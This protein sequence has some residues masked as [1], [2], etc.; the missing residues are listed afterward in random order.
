MSPF[1]G[2]GPVWSQ[3]VDSLKHNKNNRGFC[4]LTPPRNIQRNSKANNPAEHL[5]LNIIEN[6]PYNNYRLDSTKY[7]D[8]KSFLFNH[9]MVN[10]YKTLTCKQLR[11]NI[12][13]A[14]PVNKIKIIINTPRIMPFKCAIHR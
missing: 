7:I 6:I 4:C 5:A 12:L 9:F 14:D 13:N 1:V 8:I 2:V 10:K 11:S 3:K